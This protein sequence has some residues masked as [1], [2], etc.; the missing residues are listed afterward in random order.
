MESLSTIDSEMR[1][2]MLCL[3][4]EK[5]IDVI[6][7]FGGAELHY[8]PE[9][10]LLFVLEHDPELFQDRTETV[11]RRQIE[12]SDYRL[13]FP[14]GARQPADPLPI[15]AAAPAVGDKWRSVARFKMVFENL[16]NPLVRLQIPDPDATLEVDPLRPEGFASGQ[17]AGLLGFCR[18][19]PSF[20]GTFHLIRNP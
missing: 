5:H 8:A 9:F 3:L 20:E 15:D 16:R 12:I 2:E 1:F 19:K 11:L 6:Y 18:R 10:A 7:H 13:G 14:V 4:G 17:F